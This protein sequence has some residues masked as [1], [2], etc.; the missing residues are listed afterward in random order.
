MALETIALLGRIRRVL[1]LGFV[2]GVLGIR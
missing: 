1:S 2:I